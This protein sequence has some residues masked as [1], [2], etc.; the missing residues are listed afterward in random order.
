M[1][2]RFSIL[3]I[4]SLLAACSGTPT[5]KT[6][7]DP[8]AR[9]A[10]YRTYTWIGKPTGGDPLNQQRIVDGIDAK[11]QSKGW[12]LATDGDVQVGAQ[13]AAQEKRDYTTYYSAA[14]Y[15]YGWGGFGPG[16]ATTTSYTYEVGTLVVDMFDA[17]SKRAVW[18][19]S[20]SGTL[21]S[22]SDKVPALL[23]ASLDKMFANFPPGSAPPK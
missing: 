12:K 16:V 1:V 6:D 23:Q 14:G 9:F 17:K 22:N 21:P 7:F 20:A 18:H 3:A 13:V 8:A 5:V 2:H 10:S 4:A 19:G 11:L 15:G